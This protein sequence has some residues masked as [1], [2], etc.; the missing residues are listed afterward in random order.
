MPTSHRGIVVDIKEHI[1]RVGG[2]FGEWWVETAKDSHG[3]FFEGHRVAEL[4]DGFIYSEA[5]TRT[6]AQEA[7][8][9]LVKEC[10]LHLDLEDAPEPGRIIFVYRKQ[11]KSD[12]GTCDRA[13]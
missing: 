8:D 3:A 2:S 9:Y 7:R 10:D 12:G 1:R 4:H 13:E 11:G 6:G 5:Y